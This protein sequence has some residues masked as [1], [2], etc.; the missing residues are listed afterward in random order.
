[1][2][3]SF[4]RKIIDVAQVVFDHICCMPGEK[5]ESGAV[6]RPRKSSPKYRPVFAA[7]VVFA[8]FSQSD[9][10]RNESVNWEFPCL[11]QKISVDCLTPSVK[12]Y[13]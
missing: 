13:N 8:N 12:Y 10:F 7:L 1:M 6:G 3:D 11:A 9:A 5:N 4:Y 2:I